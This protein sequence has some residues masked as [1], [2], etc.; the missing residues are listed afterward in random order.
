VAGTGTMDTGTGTATG[1]KRAICTR[2]RGTR[3]RVPAGYTIP[4]SIT[5]LI[6]I[7]I[8]FTIEYLKTHSRTFEFKAIYDALGCDVIKVSLNYYFLGY[9]TADNSVHV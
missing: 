9:F 8:F 6:T 3:I 1:T 5:N 4:V 2:T 7:R